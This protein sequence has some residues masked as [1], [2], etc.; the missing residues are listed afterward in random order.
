MLPVK[1]CIYALINKYD[2]EEGQS[3]VEMALIMP[4]LLL[5]ILGIFEFGQILGSYM[6]INNLA[7][8]GARFGVIGHSDNEITELIISRPAWLDEEQIIVNIFPPYQYRQEGDALGVEVVYTVPLT[9]PVFADILPN[10]VLL[11]AQCQMRVE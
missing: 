2:N 10:P 6:V 4:V 3:M 9:M 1:N 11:S 7:R 8:E 5:L